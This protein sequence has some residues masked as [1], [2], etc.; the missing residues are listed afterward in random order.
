MNGRLLAMK[1]LN[2]G[3]DR[4]LAMNELC[5]TMRLAPYGGSKLH[6]NLIGQH[7]SALID[8]T[9][10]L[11]ILFLE[12]CDGG[13][14]TQVLMQRFKGDR[15][16][17]KWTGAAILQLLVQ[18]SEA[19]S[20]MHQHAHI[21]HND[22]KPDNVLITGFH[23]DTSS[24]RI[25]DFGLAAA[26]ECTRGGHVLG[27]RQFK[28]VGTYGYMPDEVCRLAATAA[29]K[30]KEDYIM[31]PAADVFALGVTMAELVIGK[32]FCYVPRS[33]ESQVSQKVKDIRR[34]EPSST[35]KYLKDI[36]AAMPGFTHVQ[37]LGLF[38]VIVQCV[39]ASP[40]KRRMHSIRGGYRV[41]R[42]SSSS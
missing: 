36:T 35:G 30:R 42:H 31:S 29:V 15:A 28:P 10:N 3:V 5:I 7:A 40:S 13:S 6:H 1:V 8:P 17:R 24:A 33:K 16:Q 23:S 27:P 34:G 14:A 2:N 12:L 18:I 9:T 22:I 4:I 11:P 19:L 39:D 32:W 21:V 20:A 37:L 26:M 38:Q 41:A 25:A